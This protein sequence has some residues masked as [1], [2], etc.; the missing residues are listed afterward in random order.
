[1]LSLANQLGRRIISKTA[2]LGV[3]LLIHCNIASAQVPAV[4]ANPNTGAGTGFRQTVP[5]DQYFLTLAVLYDGDYTQALGGFQS[6]QR[7]AIKSPTSFWIDSICYHTMAGETLFQMG[8]Y[9]PAVEQFNKALQLQI[10]FSDWMIPVKF[11]PAIRPLT[12]SSIRPLP[13]GASQRQMMIGAYPDSVLIQQGQIDH[14]QTI[15][16]G[17]G[18]IQQATQRSINPQEIVRCVCHALRRRREILGPLAPADALAGQLIAV[19]NKRPVQPNHW[20]ESW[21][22]AM[23]GVANA[24]IGKDA[25]AKPLLERSLLAGG[26][27]DHPMTCIALHELGRIVLDAGDYDLASKY[28][29]EAANSA[30][31]FNDPIVVE[32]SFRMGAITHFLANRAGPYQPLMTAAAWARQLDFRQ[33]Q[34]QML[35][36]IAENQC[37]LENAKVAQT[38]LDNARAVVGRRSMLQSRVGAQLNF[39]QAHV[40]YQLGNVAAGDIAVNAA[41]GFAKTG[42][43]QLFRMGLT[44]RMVGDRTLTTRGAAEVFDLLLRDPLP[45]RWIQDPLESLAVLVHPHP[46]YFERW[47]EVAMERKELDG[48]RGLEITDLAKRHKFLCTQE[49]GGRLLA[50]R[51]ILESPAEA[52]PKQTALQRQAL[53]TQFPDY[54]KLS[55]RS[56]DIRNELGQM[57]IVID[58]PEAAKLQAAKFAEWEQ[59]TRN[60]EIM[61]KVMAVRRLPTDIA[62]P[63][64]RTVEE[65]QKLLPEK[66]AVLAFFT[67]ARSTFGFLMTHDKFGYWPITA[68]TDA[69]KKLIDVL[70]GIGNYEENKVLTAADLQQTSWKETSRELFDLLTKDSKAAIPY[71][72]NELTIVPDGA[73]WYI[74]FEMLHTSPQEGAPRPLL[75]QVRIRYAPT[76]ALAVGDALPRLDKGKALVSTG[77]LFPTDSDEIAERGFAELHR[78]LPQSEQLK[79]KHKLPTSQATYAALADRLIA[80]TE[81]VPGA[82]GPLSASPLRGEKAASP[83]AALQDWVRLPWHGPEQIALPGFHSAA[84]NGMKKVTPAEMGNELFQTTMSLMASGARTVLISRWRTG[85]R[86]SY[87]LVRE[88]MQELPFSSAAQAWQRSV[89]VAMQNPISPTEEPRL[90]LDGVESAPRPEHPFFWSGYMVVDTGTEPAV[91]AADAAKEVIKVV[92]KPTGEADKTTPQVVPPGAE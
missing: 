15:A 1:M 90:R 31:Y 54:E 33:M 7:S 17:G 12:Q 88:F 62:F 25:Q 77:K 75:Q 14:T 9:G 92:P 16:R 32:D 4:V 78:A 27:F 76:L 38:T 49:L 89:F 24:A 59:T 69:Q 74:P 58:D 56:R 39:T 28:F 48:R 43:L 41:L 57:P 84:E 79:L 37:L 65:V 81:I 72:F 51:W 44:D 67:G 34:T 82:Q 68:T 83:G 3:V 71:G 22:D 60:Q 18:V 20:T 46:L 53:L 73:I 2:W 21:L 35:V 6:C 55:Q 29:Q 10:A 91:A 86:T 63:P 40:S 19:L 66:H 87:D 42:S 23:L 5:T 80:F 50:L 47:F 61:L 30:Y 26:T 36:L 70:Q 85:G 64:T 8:Q 45:A 52:L 13:W 11:N